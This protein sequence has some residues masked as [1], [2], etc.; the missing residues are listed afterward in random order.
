M[1]TFCFERDSIPIG[2]QIKYWTVCKRDT[3][4]YVIFIV[5]ETRSLLERVILIFI[6]ERRIM[7]KQSARLKKL[8][9]RSKI[10]AFTLVELLVVIAIIGI[11]IA[12]LLP[13][14]QAAREAARRIQCTNNVKQLSLALLNYGDGHKT[15]PPQLFNTEER[16]PNVFMS[17]MPYIEQGAVYE[18]YQAGPK[19]PAWSVTT[20]AGN[21][22]KANINAFLCPSDGAGLGK[23][24]H[25]V[26]MI[27]YRICIGDWAP[28][29]APGNGIM[30]G[31][32]GGTGGSRNCT[33]RLS[34]ITDGTSNTLAFSEHGI[35]ANMADPRSGA[36]YNVPGVFGAMTVVTISDG[37]SAKSDWLLSPQNCLASTSGGK[38]LPQYQTQLLMR[39]TGAPLF[40]ASSHGYSWADGISMNCSFS[41][42]LPPNSP[43]CSTTTIADRPHTSRNLLPPASYHTGGV[44][45][46]F[47]DGSVH[48]ISDT[49]S[50]GDTTAP[51]SNPTKY[52][53]YLTE[54]SVYGIFGAIGTPAGKESKS[55]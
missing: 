52:L 2:M 30:R 17:I 9:K 54:E 44:V 10:H 24:E 53:N 42:C 3:D 40:S 34:G 4:Q 50:C 51:G 47:V 41:T 21:Y 28:G 1:L 14:V 49:V 36:A 38:I 13:A 31:I 16:Q 37:A 7:K 22:L 29:S 5:L 45:A 18:M 11:L 39:P 55:L 12:L 48:F 6:Y 32:A 35:G 25:A 33:V 19:V 8:V 15:F 26:G 43:T 27:N 46:S 23:P 20:T